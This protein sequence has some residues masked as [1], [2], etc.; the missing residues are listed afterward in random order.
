MNNKT[1][2]VICITLA[3]ILWGCISI[4]MK[5]LPGDGPL[6]GGLSGTGLSTL[7]VSCV[8]LIFAAVIYALFMLIKDRKKLKIDPRD[9]WMFLL[10]GVVSVA[11]FNFLYTYTVIHSQASIGVVLLYTSPIFTMILAAIFFKEKL[12][13]RKIIA[14][15]LVFAGCVLVSGLIGGSYKISFL[16]L[17]TGLGSG[18][19]WGSYTIFSRITLQKYTSETASVWSVILAGVVMIPFAIKEQVPAQIAANPSIIWWGTG[20]AV[21]STVLPYALYTYGLT[22]VESGKASVIVS[23]ELIAGNIVGMVIFGEP[24]DTLKIIGIVLIV[25]AILLLNLNLPKKE[26]DIKN[27]L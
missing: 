8:R 23:V 5:G 16:V 24:H 21:F 11:F 25:L 6:S 4:F 15:V 20:I 12:T 18:L 7:G 3:G 10:S 14:L 9:I 22:Y 19:F 27:P 1:L 26:V 2:P 13:V 17:I